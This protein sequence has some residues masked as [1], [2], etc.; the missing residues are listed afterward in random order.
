MKI[1]NKLIWS[2]LNLFY[3]NM[4][5]ADLVLAYFAIQDDMTFKITQ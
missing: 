2:E 1:L 5:I 3:F 4:Q